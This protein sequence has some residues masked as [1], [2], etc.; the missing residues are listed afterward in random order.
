[1][2]EG[3]LNPGDHKLHSVFNQLEAETGRSSSEKPNGQNVIKDTKERVAAGDS[4]RQC[5]VAGPPDVDGERVL[6][7]ADMAGAELC[8]IADDSGDPVWVG[9]FARGEDLHSFGTELM[10]PDECEKLCLI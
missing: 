5:F 7:T 6:I 3:W 1:M 8:I 9:A 2:K 10:Y 4:I